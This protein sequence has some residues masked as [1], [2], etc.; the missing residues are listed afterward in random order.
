MVRIA[1]PGSQAFS[2]V[3]RKYCRTTAWLAASVAVLAPVA[4]VTAAGPG[5][6][7][8]VD[9]RGAVRLLKIIP[10]PPT[11]ANNTAGALYSYD[12]SWVDQ[13]TQTYYLAD[14]SNRVVGLGRLV[15]PTDIVGVQRAS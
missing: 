12:I 8:G 1:N 5:G 9:D 10:V 15:D 13:A 14:R 11:L 4:H 6:N 7:E 3:L 2:S